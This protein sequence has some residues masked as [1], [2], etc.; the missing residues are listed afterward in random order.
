M[1]MDLETAF[2]QHRHELHVHCYRMLASYDDAEDAVQEAY[3]R[4]WQARDTFDG[5]HLRAWLYR[6]ATNTCIDRARSRARR[7]PESPAEVPW[8]TAY[9]D[10][11]LGPDG[12][13][14]ERE[15]IELAFLVALQALPPR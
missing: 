12:T 11:A 6:I 13:Y 3:L 15:T 14:A 4:A 7:A 8:L 5:E 2:A 10:D 9:P 1:A